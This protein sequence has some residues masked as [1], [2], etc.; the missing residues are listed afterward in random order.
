L[1]GEDL[2]PAGT[3]VGNN[4]CLNI[5]NCILLYRHVTAIVK[6]NGHIGRVNKVTQV[7]EYIAATGEMYTWAAAAGDLEAG[8]GDVALSGQ[9]DWRRRTQSR[10]G[11]ATCAG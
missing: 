2:Y 3:I 9:I 7:D 1:I 11:T 5:G 10:I 4:A 8:Y 6:Q